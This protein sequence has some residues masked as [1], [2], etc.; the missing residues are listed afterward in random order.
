MP[1]LH[2]RCQDAVAAAVAGLGLDEVGANVATQALPS[3]REPPLPC[4]IVSLPEGRG[5]EVRPWSTEEDE[6]VLPVEVTFLDRAPK[7][8]QGRRGVWMGWREA[9]T[10]E[11]LSKRLAAVPE[12]YG[13]EVDPG[14]VLEERQGSYQ[15]VAGALTVRC[16]CVVPRTSEV[17]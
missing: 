12:C 14:P 7:D 11:F 2:E 9:L 8:W 13:L 15:L 10:R 6:V 17:A 1:T 5:E 16:R 4:V 3:E